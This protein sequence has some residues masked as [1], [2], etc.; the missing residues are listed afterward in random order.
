MELH[1]RSAQVQLVAADVVWSVCL[2]VTTMSFVKMV[3]PI[4]MPFGMWARVGPRNHAL[5]GCL[6]GPDPAHGKG[7][8]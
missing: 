6:D 7:Q 1:A 5:G 2:S 3:E 4:E 8:L